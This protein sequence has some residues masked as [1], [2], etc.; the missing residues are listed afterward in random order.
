MGRWVRLHGQWDADVDDSANG[1]CLAVL[2]GHTGSVLSLAV[3]GRGVWSG[4]ADGSIREWDVAGERACLRRV[5]DV[6]RISRL[7]PIGALRAPR[8]I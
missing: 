3:A 5:G 2:E 7:V 6:D 1:V 4:S 8:E